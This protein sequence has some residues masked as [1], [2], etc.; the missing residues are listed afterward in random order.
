MRGRGARNRGGDRS[1]VEERIASVRTTPAAG[2]CKPERPRAFPRRPAP[3]RPSKSASDCGAARRA[4]LP[5]NLRCKGLKRL[6]PRPE[7]VWPRGTPDPQHLVY[8]ATAPLA[9]PS[10]ATNAGRGRGGRKFSWLQ[11]PEKP[12]NAETLYPSRVMEL[13]IRGGDDDAAMQVRGSP[14][15][16]ASGLRCSG[17]ARSGGPEPPRGA[18]ASAP[19]NADAAE[20]GNFPGCKALKNHKTGQ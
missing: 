1:K 3:K 17:P 8:S 9:P 14:I 19:A 6:N 7:M 5:R 10:R 18:V 20:E 16:T 11:S 12:Q 2:C 13:P 15:S 4:D